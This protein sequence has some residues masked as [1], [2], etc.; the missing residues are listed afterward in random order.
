[1]LAAVV[2]AG[3]SGGEEE[4]GSGGLAWERTPRLATPP[5]LPDDRVLTGRVR[6]DSLRPI[7]LVARRDARLVDARGRQVPGVALFLDGFV[8]GLYPPTRGPH[9]LPP[10]EQRR[11]GLAAR[12]EPG[13]SVPLTVAW[14][15]GR[16]VGRPVRLQ[17]GRGSLPVPE[18]AAQGTSEP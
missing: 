15:E 8:R 18:R 10:G 4:R 16:G 6:N 12:I 2:V 14:R 17:L 13:R 1:M 5:S 7:E 9:P 3:C 11:L